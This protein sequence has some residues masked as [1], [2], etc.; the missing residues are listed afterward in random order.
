MPLQ[1]VASEVE[2]EE[3]DLLLDGL[4]KPIVH[5]S[6]IWCGDHHSVVLEFDAG[7]A[8]VDPIDVGTLTGHGNRILALPVR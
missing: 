4:G 2:V 7:V 3:F 8:R 5:R 1:H 6:H